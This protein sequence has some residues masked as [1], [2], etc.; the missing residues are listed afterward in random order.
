VENGAL[1]IIEDLLPR[2]KRRRKKNL[3]RLPGVSDRAALTGII[4]V[5]RSNGF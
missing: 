2:Q 1:N 3:G 5:L 4:L